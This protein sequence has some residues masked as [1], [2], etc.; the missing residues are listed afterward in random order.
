V[1]KRCGKKVEGVGWRKREASFV[2]VHLLRV[3]WEYKWEF[4]IDN[5]KG[6]RYFI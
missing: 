2:Y 5:K 6:V 1:A 4:L 3:W